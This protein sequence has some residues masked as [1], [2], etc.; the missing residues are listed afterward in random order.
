MEKKLTRTD[1]KKKAMIA[2]FEKSLG[3]V[4][5]AC[6]MAEVSRETHYKWLREDDKYAEAVQSVSEQAK[7]FVETKLFEQIRNGNVSSIIF[8]CKTK[9]KDR[10][11][12]ERTEHSIQQFVEQPLYPDVP[13][14]NSDK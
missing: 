10:G 4:T 1:T 3:I 2:A 7:D 6:K 12:V 5:S 11:Y 9:M 14:D 13:Q 8:Y